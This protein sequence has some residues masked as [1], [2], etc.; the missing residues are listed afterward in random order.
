MLTNQ[1][2]QQGFISSTEVIEWVARLSI[3]ATA[4]TLSRYQ[5]EGLMLLP[6]RDILKA[7]QGRPANYHPLCVSELAAATWLY[8]GFFPSVNEPNKKII[9]IA[10]FSTEDIFFARAKFFLTGGAEF[11]VKKHGLPELS[12]L[13][14][15]GKEEIKQ[16]GYE[17][18]IQL[19]A[20]KINYIEDNIKIAITDDNSIFI[21][22]NSE[23]KELVLYLLDDSNGSMLAPS[24][25]IDKLYNKEYAVAAYRMLFYKAFYALKAM[26]AYTL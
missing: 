5:K 17:G 10:R 3:S 16:I 2:M 6:N 12:L 24:M 18:Y 14:Y 13:E 4:T 25:D 22:K 20:E 7:G 26:K 8:K 19:L 1:E 15:K 23:I 11:L 21:K 9:T